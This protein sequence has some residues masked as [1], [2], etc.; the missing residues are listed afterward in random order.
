KQNSSATMRRP[1]ATAPAARVSKFARPPG[2]ATRRSTPMSRSQTAIKHEAWRKRV[3]THNRRSDTGRRK[4]AKKSTKRQGQPRMERAAANS[5]PPDAAGA[6]TNS[7]AH[8]GECQQAATTAAEAAA[9]TR[10]KYNSAQPVN[11]QDASQA[12]F[13]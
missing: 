2:G 1:N 10:S 8:N 4:P 11:G 6:R 9:A 12:R 13:R 5:G 3:I 7:S